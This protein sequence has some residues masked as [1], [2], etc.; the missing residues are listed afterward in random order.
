MP[1]QLPAFTGRRHG[2]QLAAIRAIAA[3]YAGHVSPPTAAPPWLRARL[4]KKAPRPVP[5]T[6][7]QA[8]AVSRPGGR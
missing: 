8:R 7:T 4:P 2:G 5:K 1:A 6:P 3:A